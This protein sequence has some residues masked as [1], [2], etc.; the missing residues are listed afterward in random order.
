MPAEPVLLVGLSTRALAESA[1]RA[2]WTVASV[3]GFADLDHPA[4][5]ALALARDFGLAYGPDA[6]VRAAGTVHAHVVSYVASLENHPGAVAV[7]ARGRRLWG[8][9]PAV[10]RQVRDPAVLARALRDAGL[11]ALAVR[12]TAP[13]AGSAGRRGPWLL[14]PR[15]SGGGHGIRPWRPGIAVP[16]SHV[17]QHRVDGA[18]VS[19]AFAANGARTVP[20]ALSH[21]LAGE[22]AFGAAPFQYCGNILGRVSASWRDVLARLARAADVLTA[23]FRLVGVN[24]LDAILARDGTPWVTELNPRP[25]G[26]M[27]LAERAF[28]FSVWDAHAAACRGALPAFGL[29]SALRGA[30]AVGKAV[31]FARRDVV[32]G[33]TRGWLDDPTVRD[34]PAPGSRIPAGHPI[35]TVFA[36]AR[37]SAACRAALVRRARRAYVDVEGGKRRSA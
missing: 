34:I 26:S 36:A 14:K 10:L 2:G 12:G 30:A 21:Q 8:N 33:D 18:S 16:R 22:P 37:T 11:P 7:L 27:E 1:A 19:L 4:H 6:L 15:A 25:S 31:V 29:E 3:D 28:G 9:P 5:P 20:F 32:V 23:R 24:A 13:R 17:L 35:C